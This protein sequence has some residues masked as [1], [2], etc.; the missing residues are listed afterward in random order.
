MKGLH[1]VQEKKNLSVMPSSDTSSAL[2]ASA[3]KNQLEQEEM[4]SR[5]KEREEARL[6]IEATRRRQEEE[7]ESEQLR[8]EEDQKLKRADPG[9]I[10]KDAQKLPQEEMDSLKQSPAAGA[11]IGSSKTLGSKQIIFIVLAALLLVAVGAGAALFLSR[12]GNSQPAET[13]LDTAEDTATT[14]VYDV[15]GVYYNTKD[16]SETLTLQ[17]DGT[18]VI[19]TPDGEETRGT[20]KL[21]GYKVNAL[22]VDTPMPFTFTT[23]GTLTNDDGKMYTKD[24]TGGVDTEEEMGAQTAALGDKEILPLNKN[25]SLDTL[26][27]VQQAK[28]GFFYPSSELAVTEHK[29]TAVKLTSYDNLSSL[30]VS[31]VYHKERKQGRVSDAERKQQQQGLMDSMKKNLNLKIINFKEFKTRSFGNFVGTYMKDGKEQYVNVQLYVWQNKVDK[32]RSIV[33]TI[34]ECPYSQSGDYMDLLL[35]IMRSNFDV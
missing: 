17:K 14:L 12:S 8:D 25:A 24:S 11:K 1:M 35:R 27:I 7:M 20:Y 10:G 3:A 29:G 30:S 31:V 28:L 22:V 26:A 32:S 5:A 6:A 4:D 9:D 15:T 19:V 13:S 33:A 21:V 34:L 16:N 2:F 23:T 18:F